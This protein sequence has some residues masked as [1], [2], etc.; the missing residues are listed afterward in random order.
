V[1]GDEAQSREQKGEQA[2]RERPGSH[3]FLTFEIEMGIIIF[4]P[5]ASG[6][7]K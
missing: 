7:T 1:V 2:V 6:T 4:V 3:E 5:I